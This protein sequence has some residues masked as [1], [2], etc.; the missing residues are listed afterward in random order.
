MKVKKN[1]KTL[2]TF[3]LFS[4]KS[5]SF[6]R[7]FMEKLSKIQKI[8]IRKKSGKLCLHFCYFI[9]TIF[10]PFFFSEFWWMKKN[11]FF[12]R[13]KIWISSLKNERQVIA[14]L[15][16]RNWSWK[17]G[18]IKRKWPI[19]RNWVRMTWKR[20]PDFWTPKPAWASC[21]LVKQSFTSCIGVP[22]SGNICVTTKTFMNTRLW[23]KFFNFFYKSQFWQ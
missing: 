8:R 3:L 19:S 2:F 18:G 11:R 16:T 23:S 15:T 6:W 10:L 20:W 4:V 1:R 14:H 7:F 13:K 9:L 12:L 5:T 22:D 17:N 21:A